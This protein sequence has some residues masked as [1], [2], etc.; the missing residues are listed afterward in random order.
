L[1]P[2]PL[3]YV[4]SAVGIACLGNLFL[5]TREYK[6]R[7]REY[8]EDETARLQLSG[9]NVEFLKKLKSKELTLDMVSDFYR[10]FAKANEPVLRLKRTWN[11][12]LL[13]GIAFLSSALVGTVSFYGLEYFLALY[14]ITLAFS[15]L[16]YSLY[17]LYLVEKAT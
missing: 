15:C 10:E 17:N 16:A 11:G 13:A 6:S 9:S 14:P 12:L 4:F 1:L 8:A 5:L 2:E 7:T 3:I